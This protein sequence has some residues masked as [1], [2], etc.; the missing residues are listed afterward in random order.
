MTDR[1]PIVDR[2][3]V[4]LSHHGLSPNADGGTEPTDERPLV[5][6]DFDSGAR[7]TH[8]LPID[9]TQEHAE[10]VVEVLADSLARPTRGDGQL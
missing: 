1:P 9:P 4:L 8:P 10:T 2:I 6:T 7:G 5:V 3:D